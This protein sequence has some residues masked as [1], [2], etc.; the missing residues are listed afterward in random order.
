M[1]KTISSGV[2]ESK[3]KEISEVFE[4]YQEV[5]VMIANL[6]ETLR[7]ELQ[8]KELKGMSEG[9]SKGMSKV[10]IKLLTIS[11]GKLPDELI[12]KIKNSKEEHLD[13]ISDNIFQ[14][15]SIDDLYKYLD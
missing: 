12:D 4:G 6:T 9:I 15:K 2:S 11:L 7:E 3:Q 13:V 8:R 1:K 10:V 5:E 14:L